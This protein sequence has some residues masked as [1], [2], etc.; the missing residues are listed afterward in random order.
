MAKHEMAHETVSEEAELLLTNQWLAS[1]L[2]VF[3]LCTE[4][5]QNNQSCF[6]ASVLERIDYSLRPLETDNL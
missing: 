2:Q 6:F 1:V 3:G 5:Q 4:Q